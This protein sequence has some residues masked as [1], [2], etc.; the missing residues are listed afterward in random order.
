MRFN[1]ISNG[2]D[3][4]RLTKFTLGLAF[5]F[6]IFRIILWF[7]A[8]IGVFNYLLNGGGE[9]V[10]TSLIYK[11]FSFLL[12]LFCLSMFKRLINIK[13]KFYKA[14]IY[15]VLLLLFKV[16]DLII[17]AIFGGVLVNSTIYNTLYLI[18]YG[19]LEGMIGAWLLDSDSDNLYGVSSIL[20]ISFLGGGICAVL[21]SF[22]GVESMVNLFLGGFVV[23]TGVELFAFT[24]LFWK[25]FFD[26]RLH[27]LIPDEI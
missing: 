19:V 17:V 3:K 16:I 18:V 13:Q 10:S 9:Q 25:A 14:D 7:I 8:S 22:T 27:Y 15:I 21:L 1:S 24:Y 26:R 4:L 23:L 20:G 11:A 6:S 5:L 12:L 2:I